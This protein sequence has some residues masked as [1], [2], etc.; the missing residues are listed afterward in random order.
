MGERRGLVSFTESK[1]QPSSS[2]LVFSLVFSSIFQNF[3]SETTNGG[4]SY[5]ATPTLKRAWPFYITTPTYR[6]K[7][8][9]ATQLEA[10]PERMAE[11]E[12]EEWVEAE[13]KRELAGLQHLTIED[14]ELEDQSCHDDQKVNNITGFA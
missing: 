6:N 13:I 3:H 14:L 9:R 2:L 11:E 1:Q 8:I 4:V 7:T 10:R 12:E 5:F